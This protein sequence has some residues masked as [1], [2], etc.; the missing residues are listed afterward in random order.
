[1]RLFMALTCAAAALLGCGLTLV[2]IGVGLHLESA[3]DGHGLVYAAVLIALCGFAFGAGVLAVLA[4][5]LG[6]RRGRGLPSRA[7]VLAPAAAV[8]GRRL[9]PP[10]PRQAALPVPSAQP[11]DPGAGYEYGCADDGWNPEFGGTWSPGP[12]YVW[13]PAGGHNGANA[14]GERWWAPDD[15]AEWEPAGFPDW[16]DGEP[17]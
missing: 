6:G 10:S 14:A 3:A 15:R 9:S 5:D 16:D 13:A 11:A 2:C 17:E 4:A 12:A 7:A 8:P 1:M